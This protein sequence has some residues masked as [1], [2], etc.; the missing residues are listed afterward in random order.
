MIRTTYRDLK[1]LFWAAGVLIDAPSIKKK[2]IRERGKRQEQFLSSLFP[3]CTPKNQI[4]FFEWVHILN[5]TDETNESIA[6]MLIK[7]CQ[8]GWVTLNGKGNELKIQYIPGEDDSLWKRRDWMEDEDRRKWN[9]DRM[10]HGVLPKDQMV[11]DYLCA[12]AQG[13]SVRQITG[14][15]FGGDERMTTLMVRD[16]LEWLVE[17]KLAT[18]EEDENG[19]LLF[20]AA[21]QA[22]VQTQE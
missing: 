18:V 15:V 12:D 22:A 20:R 19:R 2:R 10:L 11:L 7:L 8:D 17:Q 6:Q 21:P 14:E 3:Y 1:R 9:I 5:M 16:S 13:S 4:D